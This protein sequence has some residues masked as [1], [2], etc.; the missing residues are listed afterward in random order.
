MYMDLKQIFLFLNV[1]I[2]V[3]VR[4]VRLMV[5]VI[6]IFMVRCWVFRL[7]QV[8]LKKGWVLQNIIGV[9][10]SRLNQ[11]KKLMNFGDRLLIILK[12]SGNVSIM[13]WNELMFVSIS[14]INME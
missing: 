8:L 11:W 14:F 9:V 3:L 5:M 7:C 4:Y 12:Y 6:G 1:V 2:Q 10:I 13:F